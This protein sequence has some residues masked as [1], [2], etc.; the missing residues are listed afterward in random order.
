MHLQRLAGNQAV[1][2]LLGESGGVRR[3]LDSDIAVAPADSESEHEAE[4]HEQPVTPPRLT[5]RSHRPALAQRSPLAGGA[6]GQ[7]L[8]GSVRTSMEASLGRDLSG[9]RIHR[10]ESAAEMSDVLG[11]EAFTHGADVFVSR[12]ADESTI[13]HEVTH[14]ALHGASNA[15]HLKRVKKHVDF[16]RFKRI[17]G[18]IG[19]FAIAKLFAGKVDP[20]SKNWFKKW[21]TKQDDKADVGHWWVELG[22][23]A[24]AGQWTP[25]ES[26]GWYPKEKPTA[27]GQMTGIGSKPVEGELNAGEAT[28]HHQGDAADVEFHPVLEV[29]DN[30]AYEAVRDDIA[31]KVRAFAKGYKGSW[32]WRFGWGKNCHKF[33]ED[34]KKHLGVHHQTS[35]YWLR[36]AGIKAKTAAQIMDLIRA[37][38]AVGAG[39]AISQSPAT[40]LPGDLTL[41]DYQR[42]SA[43]NRQ[44][45][46]TLVDCTWQ[47]MNSALGTLYGTAVAVFRNTDAPPPPPPPPPEVLEQ[48]KIVEPPKPK[49]PEGPGKGNV[50]R[51]QQQAEFI[52][53]DTAIGML[54]GGAP[55]TAILG[56][57]S[58]EQIMGFDDDVKTYLATIMKLTASEFD[59]QQDQVA[60]AHH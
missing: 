14:A 7:S 10:D 26:Y 2:S 53:G 25:H 48:P 6:P 23:L 21:V 35:K 19:A 58:I 46:L 31:G 59:K 30:A 15:V 33:Q 39:E 52:V 1:V 49:E 13:R 24:E 8:A 9:V 44:E 5:R 3:L 60:L 12:Q 57:V 18:D 29:D 37:S 16:L 36:G 56:E 47:Q 41:A 17:T 22:S 55:L 27:I 45:L 28:D 51:G 32:Y 50:V 34:M 20:A 38:H 11:A 43:G 54:K 40:L 4:A 42:L